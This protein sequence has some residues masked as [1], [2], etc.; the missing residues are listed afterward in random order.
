MFNVHKVTF[1]YIRILHNSV[2]S[3]SFSIVTKLFGI[4]MLLAYE[5]MAGFKNG[6]NV[7]ELPFA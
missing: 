7:T 4:W 6:I 2:V 5:V 3:I 1:K